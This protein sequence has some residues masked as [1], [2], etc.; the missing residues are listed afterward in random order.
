MICKF[1]DEKINIKNPLS[2]TCGHFICNECCINNLIKIGFDERVNY[3]FKENFSLFCNCEKDGILDI[4]YNNYYDKL[5]LLI[6]SE[7]ILNDISK[8]KDIIEKSLKLFQRRNFEDFFSFLNEEESKIRDLIEIKKEEMLNEITEIIKIGNKILNIYTNY[9]EKITKKITFIFLILRQNSLIHYSKLNGSIIDKLLFEKMNYEI[10]S[11]SINLNLKNFG[12]NNIKKEFNKILQD[13]KSYNEFDNQIDFRI[14]STKYILKSKYSFENAHSGSIYSLYKIN[15]ETIASC[16]DDKLIKFWNVNNKIN[17][18]I[19]HHKHPVYSFFYNQNKIISSS[20]DKT[21]RIWELENNNLDI[22]DNFKKINNVNIIYS[23]CKIS[24]EIFCTSS[25]D[26]TI[27]IWDFKTM[28]LLNTLI[29]HNDA[30]YSI[31]KLKNEKLY[32]CSGDKTI[33]IWDLATGICENTLK[34]H[35]KSIYS[36]CEY[37]KNKIASA[38]ADNS[39]KLW[40]LNIVN[41]NLEINCFKT[42]FGHYNSVNKVGKLKDGF[43]FSGSDDKTIRIWEVKNLFICKIILFD[44]NCGINDIIKINNNCIASCSGDKSIKIWDLVFDDDYYSTPLKQILK[45]D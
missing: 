17:T 26:K 36:I 23:L 42:L 38:S 14:Q 28:K 43:I 45:I 15:N 9:F 11:F 29:G 37:E 10:S 32:S 6:N 24:D 21:I 7:H 1:C 22:N 35:L 31:I 2:F 39:I 16:S 8:K 27:K 19:L 5:N 12:L 25:S 30:V 4:D 20:S 3:A 41:D 40:D 18:K 34:G 13:I 33:K 44:H